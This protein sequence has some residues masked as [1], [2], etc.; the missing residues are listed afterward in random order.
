[1]ESRNIQSILIKAA[2]NFILGD[3]EIQDMLETLCKKN[4][5]KSNCSGPE[6][7][8]FYSVDTTTAENMV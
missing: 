4:V 2:F 3:D 1:M 6:S 7:C 5:S 8:A